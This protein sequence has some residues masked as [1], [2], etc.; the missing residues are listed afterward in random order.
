MFLQLVHF[1]IYF[2]LH[3]KNC[4]LLSTLGTYCHT[5]G[6]MSLLQTAGAIPNLPGII[7]IP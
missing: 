5:A 6:L 1:N 7:T 4:P 2:I 3:Y